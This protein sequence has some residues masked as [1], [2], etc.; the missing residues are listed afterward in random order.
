MAILNNP[1]GFVGYSALESAA[2]EEVMQN[3]HKLMRGE[4]ETGRVIK[5][6][7]KVPPQHAAN[8]ALRAHPPRSALAPARQHAANTVPRSPQHTVFRTFTRCIM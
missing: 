2:V 4:A 3:P 8:S 7:H 6:P 1:I 5:N